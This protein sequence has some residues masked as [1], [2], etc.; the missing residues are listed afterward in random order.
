MHHV[1]RDSPRSGC[2]DKKTQFLL[3][4]R[5]LINDLPEVRTNGV[6]FSAVGNNWK[7][8]ICRARGMV[9]DILNFSFR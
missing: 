1:C 2:P 3:W 8:N 4:A 7:A 9:I 6:I 5:M